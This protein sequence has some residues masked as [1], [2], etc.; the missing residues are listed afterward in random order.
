MLMNFQSDE[1][2]EQLLGNFERLAAKPSGKSKRAA[3]NAAV[4]EVL[5]EVIQI[6]YR[7]AHEQAKLSRLAEL[8][9]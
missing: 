5:D 7:D 4:K 9:L 2:L 6:C 3:N 8:E 1:K